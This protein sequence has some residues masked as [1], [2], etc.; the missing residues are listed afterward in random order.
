MKKI[1]FTFLFGAMILFSFS[2]S[3]ERHVISS[4]GSSTTAGG[5]TLS[6]TV[7]E[8]ATTTLIS[9]SVVLTQGFQQPNP[10]DLT[11]VPEDKKTNLDYKIYPNPTSDQ[12]IIELNSDKPA[13][14]VIEICDM[15]GKQV[16]L[17]KKTI[18]VSGNVKEQ[19]DMTS[20]AAGNYL[21]KLIYGNDAVKTFQVMK[22]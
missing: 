14:L 21:L 7:G 8:I 5:I 6:S 19:V 20:F 16:V 2:Q 10:E 9:G 11:S 1:I 3:I 17:L 18:H 13:E 22:K 4:T 12:L 15:S